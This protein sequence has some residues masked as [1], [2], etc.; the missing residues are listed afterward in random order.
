M[1]TD[2]KTTRAFNFD[3]LR[4][5]HG[6]HKALSKKLEG[7]ANWKYISDYAMGGRPISDY[8]ARAIESRIGFPRLWLDRDNA[9]VLKSS[10]DDFESF[11]LVRR[12]TPEIRAAMR[13]LLQHANA[14][15]T[16]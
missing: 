7:I 3:L 16:A 6:G 14:T 5:L 12:S 1:A 9:S 15:A 13:T 8:I 11:V 4:H 2:L 10:T